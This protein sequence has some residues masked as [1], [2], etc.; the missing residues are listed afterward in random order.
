MTQRSNGQGP[1]V[2]HVAT[3]TEALLDAF[4]EESAL[5]KAYDA[6]LIRRLLPF[7]KPYRF[8]L[9]LSLGL[10]FVT[11]GLALTRPW[12]MRQTIDLG[13]VA[14]DRHRLLQGGLT[15]AVIV[16]V[17]QIL[18]FVQ[19]ITMQIAGARSMTDMRRHVFGFLHELRLRYFDEQPVGRLVTRVT[20]DVDAILELFSSGALNAVVDLVRLVGIV[21]VMVSLDLPGCIG[22]SQVARGVS[23][24]SSQDRAHERHHERAS[25]RHDG[26]SGFRSRASGGR[27]VRHDQHRLPRCQHAFDGVRGDSRR[28]DRDGRFGVSGIDRHIARIPAGELWHGCGVQRLSDHVL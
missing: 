13:V 27:R 15:F 12:I 5:G 16:V 22:A 19:T 10:G 28:R 26:G 2:A 9:F 1:R 3:K 6:R 11:A 14:G 20:N 17:E 8:I 24:D 7:V 18:N 21:V 4:H 25:L 23:R